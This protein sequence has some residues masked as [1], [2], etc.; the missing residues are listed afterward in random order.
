MEGPGWEVMPAAASAARRLRLWDRFSSLA[1]ASPV[2]ASSATASPSILD[3][4]MVFI[5]FSA[6]AA[7]FDDVEALVISTVLVEGA[8]SASTTSSGVA[9][10]CAKA[11]ALPFFAL[12]A[13]F[14]C[15]FFVSFASAILLI[16][17]VA[18]RNIG[19]TEVLER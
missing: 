17:P 16:C 6:F 19:S 4:F 2:A 9:G 14:F 1:G 15:C 8:S 13:T 12:N 3:T 5:G 10:W 18:S 11:V 7:F